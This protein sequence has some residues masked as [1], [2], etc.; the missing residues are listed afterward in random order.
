MFYSHEVLTSR[1]Y[2]VATVWLVATLGSK[3]TLKRV[4]RKAIL[5]VDVQKACETIVTP[6]APMALRLQSNLLYGVARVYSQQCGYV[7]TDAETARNNMRAVFKVLRTSA[8]DAE[9]GH[10]GRS[11]QLLLQDDPNF[12]PDFDLMPIDLE[13]LNFDLSTAAEESQ[14]S[15]LSPHSSQLTVGSLQIPGQSSSVIGGPVGGFGGGFS[16]RGDSGAGARF[17]NGG[18][19][20][21]DLGITVEP[22]GTMR[23]SDAPRRQ[24]AAPSG[25]V[26]RTDLGSVSSRV[27]DEHEGGQLGQEMYGQPDDDGFMPLQDDY[28][29]GADAEAFP[30]HGAQDQLQQQTS[31]ET[32]DAP[33]RRRAR[34]APKVIAPDATLE[35][36]NSD[37][38]RWN[39]DY[40]ANMQDVIKHKEAAK[41]VAIAKKNAEHWVLGTTSLSALGQADR[42]VHGPLGMFSGVK[43]LEALTGFRLT[44]GGEKRGREVDGSEGT[45]RVRSRGLEPSSDELGRGAFADDGYMPTMGDDYTGIEQGREAPT[46]LDDRPLSNTFPWNQST[47]SRRPTGV[48]GSTSVAGAGTQL[49]ALGRRGSRLQSGSPL[50]GR[51]LPGADLGA[52][53]ELRQGIY[54]DQTG[55]PGDVDMTGLD[56]FELFGPAAEVD[57]QTAAQSQWQRAILDSESVNFLAFVR[58]GIEEADQ[59]REQAGTGDEDDEAVNGSIEFGDLLPPESNSR[60]VA[61]QALLHVLAL[62]TKNLLQVEQEEPFGSI[63]MRAV[64]VQRVYD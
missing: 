50:V 52:M 22:D 15:T 14:R 62:G 20:D 56:D 16:V 60:I 3:S 33:L 55:G 11:D 10:K 19:L 44:S 47:G 58:A 53:D 42:L 13:Q 63:A 54:S 6:E 59:V 9:G 37:L 61:A 48:F 2:G 51:G 23:F 64:A 26:D 7:L 57:T 40:V 36:R 49:G 1:K 17:D 27:R 30:P 25:R 18:F 5:D 41:A 29:F 38:A 35:L 32:A 46:P 45:R 34:A 43:L 28:A 12:L 39:T 24:P 21:D 4:S 31:S 8:L